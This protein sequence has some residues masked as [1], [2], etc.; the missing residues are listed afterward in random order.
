M[1]EIL[2]AKPC[3]SPR[4]GCG[5]VEVLAS[6]ETPPS[7]PPPPSSWLIRG[8]LVTCTDCVNVSTVWVMFAQE[9][10]RAIFA[11][12]SAYF[13]LFHYLTFPLS[14]LPSLAYTKFCCCGLS[15]INWFYSSLPNRFCVYRRRYHLKCTFLHVVELHGFF[16]ATQLDIVLYSSQHSIPFDIQWTDF[17]WFYLGF[18]GVFN[19]VQ[20]FSMDL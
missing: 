11:Y 10:I 13:H 4:Y 15:V 18:Q 3:R 14:Y 7:T 12:G 16:R 5:C 1:A 9:N 6:S 20:W 2:W 19:G 17:K 8:Q